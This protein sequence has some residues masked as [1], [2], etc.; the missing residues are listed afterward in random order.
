MRQFKANIFKMM[1]ETPAPPVTNS[2]IMFSNPI[3]YQQ[4]GT[5]NPYPDG[6]GTF[7]YEVGQCD[8]VFNIGG[9]NISTGDILTIR[10]QSFS[11]FATRQCC[12][13]QYAGTV[14]PASSQI[15][16]IMGTVDIDITYNGINNTAQVILFTPTGVLQPT[17]SASSS[18]T[19]IKINGND[20]T[21][22]SATD[23]ANLNTPST[24]TVTLTIS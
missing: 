22:P 6:G 16:P 4:L 3:V 12:L 9:A 18:M 7:S 11:S 10:F 8:V 17:S 23:S 14:N 19:L 15:I 20:V 13:V 1:E 5:I 24:G 21:F 2:Q